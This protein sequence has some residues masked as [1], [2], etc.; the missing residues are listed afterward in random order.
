[1]YFNGQEAEVE[2]PA[3]NTT[4]ITESLTV[5]TPPSLTSGAAEVIL[6]NH[7]SGT[8]YTGALLT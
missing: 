8:A 5:I 4:T 3:I 7:D 2:W 1:V 6:V